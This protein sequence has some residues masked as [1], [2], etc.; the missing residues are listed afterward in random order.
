MAYFDPT[1]WSLS[2]GCRHV[3]EFRAVSSL[4][5]KSLI[6]RTSFA[7]TSGVSKLRLDTIRNETMHYTNQQLEA[8]LRKIAEDGKSDGGAAVV[9]LPE[10]LPAD[11]FVPRQDVVDF[12]RRYEEYQQQSAQV[13]VGTY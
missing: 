4:V 10:E 5:R 6:L 7:K 11:S 13:N 8:E 3:H 2:E 9:R 12:V 1:V